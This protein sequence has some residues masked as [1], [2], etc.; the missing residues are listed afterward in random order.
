MKWSLYLP[1]RHVQQYSFL[2]SA[3][4]GDKYSALRLGRFTPK[5]ITPSFRWIDILSGRFWRRDKSHNTDNNGCKCRIEE[6]KEEEEEEEGYSISL[7]LLQYLA[8]YF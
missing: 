1:Q 8:N 6:E 3:L 2:G 4:Y 5:K 7:Y